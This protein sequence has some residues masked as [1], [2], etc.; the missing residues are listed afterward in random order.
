MACA[1][2]RAKFGL[3][4]R[5]SD[6]VGEMSVDVA[7]WLHGLGLQQYEQAICDNAIN[8]AVCRS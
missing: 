3:N 4:Q 1:Q 2:K 6:R 8:A 5:G 7:A